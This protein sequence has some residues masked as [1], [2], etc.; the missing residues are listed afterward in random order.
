VVRPARA[1]PPRAG[2]QVHGGGAE[3]AGEDR[4]G[5]PGRQ[6]SCSPGQGSAKR[7]RDAVRRGPRRRRGGGAREPALCQRHVAGGVDAGLRERA[8]GCRVAVAR[9]PRGP[10]PGAMPGRLHAHGRGSGSRGPRRQ[11]ARR[12]RR[13]STA[14]RG[15]DGR[16]PGPSSTWPSS[17]ADRPSVACMAGGGSQGPGGAASRVS[18]PIPRHTSC[19]AGAGSVTPSVTV[20]RCYA[21]LRWVDCYDRARFLVRSEARRLARVVL[22]HVTEPHGAATRGG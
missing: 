20:L 11:R 7:Q 2:G 19:D 13:T 14:D 10:R 5:A 6:P 17:G 3:D 9:A 16:P 1:A 21:L 22:R 15:L 8:R 4:R 12:D 18:R